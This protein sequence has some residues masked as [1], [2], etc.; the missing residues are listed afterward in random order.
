[1][2]ES[3]Q[4]NDLLGEERKTMSQNVH[5]WDIEIS[6]AMESDKRNWCMEIY[7]RDTEIYKLMSEH[8]R[9]DLREFWSRTSLYILSQ[10]FLFAGFAALVARS[11][12][13]DNQEVPPHW[14]DVTFM[15]ILAGIGVV[16]AG[17]GFFVALASHKWIRRWRNEMLNLDVKGIDRFHCFSKVEVGTAADP[18]A[19][20]EY[21]KMDLKGLVRKG[22]VRNDP[23]R[24]TLL[25]PAFFFLAWFAIIV[26]VVLNVAFFP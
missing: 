23:V 15:L 21:A 18:E 22:K 16:V 5:D 25:V 8:Y 11:R 26:V 13:V 14:H 9:Q 3:H 2:G 20:V 6:K 24:L 7:K 19:A 4:E 17:V 1:M 10:A 12:V